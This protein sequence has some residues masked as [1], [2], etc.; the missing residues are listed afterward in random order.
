MHCCCSS[1]TDAAM[2]GSAEVSLQGPSIENV[3]CPLDKLNVRILNREASGDVWCC[4]ENVKL[5]MALTRGY[6]FHLKRPPRA[7]SSSARSRSDTVTNCTRCGRGPLGHAC[8]LGG[9][10]A[11]ARAGL[12]GLRGLCGESA[13]WTPA[14][15]TPLPSTTPPLTAAAAAADTL[16]DARCRKRVYSCCAASWMLGTRCA[17]SAPPGKDADGR[18]A[19]RLPGE[20]L[21]S[22]GAPA[23]PS[24]AAGGGTSALRCRVAPTAAA[25][26]A[27]CRP[28]ASRRSSSF[29]KSTYTSR[30]EA[31]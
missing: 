1:L 10:A 25:W 21:P 12:P 14:P 17:M 27:A 15:S 20:E 18:R 22:A 9:A 30:P 11:T 13:K 2:R 29:W 28:A 8:G 19:V 3:I 16:P 7:R 31:E 24:A 6:Q 26:A 5:R 4:S 23:A